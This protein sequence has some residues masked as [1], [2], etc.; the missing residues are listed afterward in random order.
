MGIG[1]E[2]Q[3]GRSPLEPAQCKLLDRIEAD[4][5]EPDAVRDRRGDHRFGKHLEQA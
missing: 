4:R 5:A 3:S 2:I 1:P